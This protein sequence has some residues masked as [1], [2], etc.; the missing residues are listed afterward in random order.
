MADQP[1]RHRNRPDSRQMWEESERRGKNPRDRRDDRG[2]DREEPHRERERDRRYRSRSRSPRGGDRG[3]KHR[4]RRDRD[5]R[6]RNRP[7]EP[8]EK[9]KEKE[10]DGPR[11][12]DGRRDRK[13][14]RD[15][16]RRPDE[17]GAFRNDN[18]PDQ[19]SGLNRDRSIRRSAS[20]A[21]SPPSKLDRSSHNS[22]LPTRLR[23]GGGKP[24]SSTSL[25][26]KVMKH[27]DDG[28]RGGKGGA[29]YK[30]RDASLDPDRGRRTETPNSDRGDA[31]DED[32]DE[33][34]EELVVE[35]DGLSAMQAMMGF[36][37]FGTTKGSH[38]PGN[39]AG[40]VRKEK[41]AEYRQYMNRVGGFN[42]PLSP[43]R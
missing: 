37:G 24:E 11:R 32:D 10:R 42:R 25:Q 12:D 27:D 6:P 13:P 2:R 19:K 4:D 36:G 15:E 29:G 39:N 20:P 38:I 1:R 16:G 9:E 3:G 34:D 21:H 40:G 5:D 28:S 31:M 22:P 14:I 41:K 17:R 23:H 33:D 8:K 26:F 7:Q 43:S 30:G 18:P 35:D